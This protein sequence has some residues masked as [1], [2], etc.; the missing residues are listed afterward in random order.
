MT[1]EYVLLFSAVTDAIAELEELR[2]LLIRAQQDAEEIYI[3]RE[4]GR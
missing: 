1:K 4:E 3:S 2:E